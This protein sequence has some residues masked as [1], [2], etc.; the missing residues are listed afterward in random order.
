MSG[1][2]TSEEIAHS[3][4]W[5]VRSFET[6]GA[7]IP[8]SFRYGDRPS[9]ALLPTWR[10]EDGPDATS[11]RDPETGLVCRCDVIRYADFPAVEWVLRFTNTGNR[12]TPIIADIEPLDALVQAKDEPARLHHAN[13]SLCRFDDF[14]AHETELDRGARHRIATWGGRSSNGALPFFNLALGGRGIIVAIGWTGDW[15]AEF[16]RD[17]EGTVRMVAGMQRT[18]LKL[19]PGET[20]RTPRIVLLFW[21]GE[22]LHGHN[23]LRRFILGH[24]APQPA[25]SLVEVLSSFALWGEN[26]VAR[27]LEKAHWFVEK[28]I[29]V[30]NYWI[31][32]GWHGDG[33]FHPKANV[34]N[35]PWGEHVGNWWPNRANYP[36]GLGPI[37]AFVREHGMRFTL[38]FESERVYRGT[39]FARERPGWLLGPIGDNWLF[40]LGNPEAR[41]GLADAISSVIDEGCITCYRQDFNMDPA[42]F[43]QAADAP[44]RIGMHEIR[45][46]EGLYAFWDDLRARH[47]GLIIDNC[48]SGGRRIDLETINRSIP[49]WRSDFQCYPDFDPIGMQGQTHG[50]SLWVPLS[51]GCCDRP[52]AY[53]FRSTLLPGVVVCTTV[54][55]PDEP[56]GVRTPW[57]AYPVEWLRRMLAEQK[58]V[59][60]YAYGDFTPLLSFSLADDVWAAWQWHR[61]DLCEG[62]VV[63]LRRPKSPFTSMTAPL[64]GLDADARYEVR[65]WDGGAVTR[66]AGSEL[67]ARG[68][69]ITID[70]QPGSR[71]FTYRRVSWGE[72]GRCGGGHTGLRLRAATGEVMVRRMW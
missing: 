22:R 51:T 25:D 70:E 56:E 55:G 61:A 37:G 57:D 19:L 65:A 7:A 39:W 8:F 49:L 60:R 53:A 66:A 27:Q 71:L 14:A 42:P 40:D 15:A 30:D 31:D 10:R 20:I 64:H 54:A 4:E 3:S 26:T 5:F 34:F 2:P 45:H 41:A 18:H 16:S 68:L 21:E 33:E 24:H 23:M 67:A 63:A 52:D 46:I 9:S 69:T 13:G 44:D 32:A 47:P 58:V 38:W 1:L 28:G 59:R 72:V 36:D 35:T 11:F 12:E 17:H 43:W 29:D 6:A 62:A 50:L 48:S